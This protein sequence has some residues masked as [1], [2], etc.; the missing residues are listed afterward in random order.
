MTKYVLN[1]GGLRNEPEKAKKFLA[2]VLNGLGD[3]PHMLMCHFA[4][5]RGEWEEKFRELQRTFDKWYP[6]NIEATTELALPESF[7]KQIEGADA[8]YLHGG[9]DD[10]VGD[11]LRQFDILRIW[12]GKVVATNSASSHALAKHFS[13][14][15]SAFCGTVGQFFFIKVVVRQPVVKLRFV[16]VE[17]VD[18]LFDDRFDVHYNR[19]RKWIRTDEMIG[20]IGNHRIVP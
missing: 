8:L 7:Q 9:D 1:S 15:L 2:E 5:P 3:K 17:H 14:E 16:T 12:D 19:R 4:Q 18:N 6:E 10:L 13:Q 11:L 20:E